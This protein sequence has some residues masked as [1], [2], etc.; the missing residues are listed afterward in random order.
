[1]LNHKKKCKGLL[2]R[3]GNGGFFLREKVIF[4]AND[5]L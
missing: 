1:M 4:I 3:V 5:L 2:G